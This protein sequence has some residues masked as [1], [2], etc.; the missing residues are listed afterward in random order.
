MIIHELLPLSNE[1]HYLV[2]VASVATFFFFEGNVVT[3][4]GGPL[5]TT[6]LLPLVNPLCHH[7]G[8]QPQDTLAVEHR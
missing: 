5:V 2:G 3:K 8:A 4:L 6:T 7:I 1:P